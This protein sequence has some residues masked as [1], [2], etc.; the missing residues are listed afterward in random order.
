MEVKRS[1]YIKNVKQKL[2][3]VFE[4]V[5]IRPINFYFI[6]KVKK[7]FKKDVEAISACLY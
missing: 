2:A 1:G 6:L 3:I 7:I 4:I 5:D